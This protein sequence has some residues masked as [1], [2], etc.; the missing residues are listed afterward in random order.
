M[1]E[2]E[3]MLPPLPSMVVVTG[4]DGTVDSPS[5]MTL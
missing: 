4:P 5:R 1:P 2:T 3:L